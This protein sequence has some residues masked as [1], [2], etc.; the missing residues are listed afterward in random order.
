MLSKP[1]LNDLLLN[2]T[3]PISLTLRTEFIKKHNLKTA[4]L[5]LIYCKREYDAISVNDKKSKLSSASN[6]PSTAAQGLERAM[7]KVQ[8][9]ERIKK[10][11]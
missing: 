11:R 3:K 2:A 6:L 10:R 8:Q 1:F 9:P 4:S 7:K 5:L